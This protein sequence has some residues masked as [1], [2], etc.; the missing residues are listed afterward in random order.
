MKITSIKQQVKNPERASIFVD[1]KY[2]LSL[3]LNELVAEKLKINQE[4]DEA[5]HKRLKKMSE[6]G[7]QKARALEWVLNRPRSVR[8]FKDY[9]F[10][11][12][13]DPGLTEKLIT[14]FTERNYI[15]EERFAGWLSDVRARRGKSNR[16]IQAELA[17][18]GIA[19]ET[20]KEVLADNNE[21]ERLK[22]LVAKKGKLPRYKADPQKLIRYLA[23]HGFSYD[24]IKNVLSKEV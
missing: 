13:A 5:A 23:S 2:S 22:E 21:I 6:D 1:G 15:N 7:K 20:V 16:A 14:E 10:H 4:L 19:R 12:K 11:K 8:E 18:K 17:S 24:D 3:T 9:M